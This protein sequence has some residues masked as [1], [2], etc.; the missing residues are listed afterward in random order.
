M[1]KRSTSANANLN[2]LQKPL[3]GTAPCFHT[4]QSLKKIRQQEKNRQQYHGN[5]IKYTTDSRRT[6]RSSGG[7]FLMQMTLPYWSGTTAIFL[8]VGLWPADKETG[9][10]VAGRGCRS[11]A[12]QPQ[13][14]PS[15]YYESALLVYEPAAKGRKGQLVYLQST[16]LFE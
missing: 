10:T 9:C 11:S 8:E 15:R 5:Q 14:L 4:N 12:S 6:T 13:P 16:D 2:N 3:L 7:F 1:S